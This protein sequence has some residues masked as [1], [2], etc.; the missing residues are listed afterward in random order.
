MEHIGQV[1]GKADVQLINL[2]SLFHALV[3]LTNV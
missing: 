3:F 2:L 1:I